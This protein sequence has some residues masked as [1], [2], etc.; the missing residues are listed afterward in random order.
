M[1]YMH[2]LLEIIIDFENYLCNKAKWVR[3]KGVPPPIRDRK[4]IC[5]TWIEAS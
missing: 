1:E 5:R 4:N 2:Y 3:I